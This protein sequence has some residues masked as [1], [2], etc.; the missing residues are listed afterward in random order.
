MNRSVHGVHFRRSLTGLMLELV[1]RVT[2]VVPEQVICPA[3][4]FAFGIHIGAAEEERLNHKVLQ[5]EFAFLDSIVD[6]LM[7]GIEPSR[8][9][10]HC[11]ESGFLCDFQDHFRVRKIV[12]NRNF[13]LH[14]LAGSHHLYRLFGVH[15]G[16]RRQNCGFDAGLGKG[17]GEIGCP[18]RDPILFGDSFRGVGTASGNRNDLRTLDARESVE[19]L[20]G[21]CS[22]P[23][24]TDLHEC[25]PYYCW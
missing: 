22:L 19:M 24:H 14:V 15:L 18:V 3:A 16:G 11:G 13:D 2:G 8:V 25:P 1:D 4:W 20:L 17:F 5:R 21:E 10:A 12:C 23:N 6:P 7:A 9:S